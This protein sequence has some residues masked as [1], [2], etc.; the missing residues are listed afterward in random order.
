MAYRLTAP[1]LA[2]ELQAAGI[3][4]TRTT[5]SAWARKYPGLA[6]RVGGRD[7]FQPQVISLLLAGTPLV[8]IAQMLRRGTGH[9][10]HPA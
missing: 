5:T 4:I 8:E 2:A 10:Q 7:F 1:E 9:E 3:P 6:I